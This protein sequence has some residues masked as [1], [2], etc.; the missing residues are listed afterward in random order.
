MVK[1]LEAIILFNECKNFAEN[2]QSKEYPI[3]WKNVVVIR[4]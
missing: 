4:N 1:Y 3:Y 2:R